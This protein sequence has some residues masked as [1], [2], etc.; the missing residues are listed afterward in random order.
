[1]EREVFPLQLVVDAAARG[2]RG[3][4]IELPVATEDPR[5]ELVLG[6]SVG[7]GVEMTTR[8][9]HA[10]AAGL[11]L[12]KKRLPEGDRGALILD[13]KA[14][15]AGD[16]HGDGLERVEPEIL[17]FGPQAAGIDGGL[18]PQWRRGFDQAG[19]L[20]HRSAGSGD[21]DDAGGRKD[22][23]AEDQPE[24]ATLTDRTAAGT[25]SWWHGDSL[26]AREVGAGSD[27]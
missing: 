4:R 3:E 1:M 6:A 12:P 22:R 25:V 9:S 21:H 17:R 20:S 2:T 8:T 27:E 23:Q 24:H 11:L 5:G 16:R 15:V 18:G 7:A 10:V 19:E 13:V 14:D 26:V